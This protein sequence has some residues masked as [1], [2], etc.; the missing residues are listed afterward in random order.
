MGGV[1]LGRDKG[2]MGLTELVAFWS[3][4]LMLETMEAAREETDAA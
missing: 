3:A 1:R 4:A 2:E